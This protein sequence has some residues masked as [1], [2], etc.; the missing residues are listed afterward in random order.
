VGP[1]RFR[2][3]T[4]AGDTGVERD[5]ACARVSF[6]SVASTSPRRSS[7]PVRRPMHHLKFLAVAKVEAVRPVHLAELLHLPEASAISLPTE[8]SSCGPP[9]TAWPPGAICRIMNLSPLQAPMDLSPCARP[10]SEAARRLRQCGKALGRRAVDRRGK[11]KRRNRPGVCLALGVATNSPPSYASHMAIVGRLVGAGDRGGR[12][13]DE[14][15]AIAN[16]NI[17]ASGSLHIVRRRW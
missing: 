5:E 16:K 9:T 13:R 8:K 11:R 3:A 6:L 15:N 1:Q 7:P 10:S 4:V 12:K 2:F 17:L 14:T